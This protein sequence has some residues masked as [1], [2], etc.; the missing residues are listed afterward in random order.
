[1]V[2]TVLVVVVVVIA[3]F[4]LREV[5]MEEM[6]PGTFEPFT[7]TMPFSSTPFGGSV[8]DGDGVVAALVRA[9]ATRMGGRNAS[10]VFTG[11]SGTRVRDEGDDAALPHFAVGTSSSLISLGAPCTSAAF[12]FAEGVTSEEDDGNKEAAA[13]EAGAPAETEKKGVRSSTLELHKCG[14]AGRAGSEDLDF[15][16]AGV[17]IRP[18]APAAVVEWCSVV[19]E[20]TE[21]EASRIGQHV[22]RWAKGELPN[23]TVF[24]SACPLAFLGSTLFFCAPGLPPPFAVGHGVW[25]VVEEEEWGVSIS[26][27]RFT[28]VM[29]VGE[30]VFGR[31]VTAVE[32]QG[33]IVTVTSRRSTLPPSLFGTL[34][35]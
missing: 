25:A 19:E 29:A 5:P 1:M 15:D 31:M 34:T 35:S 2:L 13:V 30:V 23:V 28:G 24:L 12:S 18:L 9:V 6:V 33:V 10:V 27:S 3:V 17:L 7:A 14:E 8:W 21:D 4:A 16:V 32:V 22:R 26:L 20:G 11:A